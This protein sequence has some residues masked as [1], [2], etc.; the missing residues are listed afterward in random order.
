M[1]DER[2]LLQLHIEPRE[3]IEV[4]EL[5]GALSEVAHQ[6]DVFIREQDYFERAEHGRLLISN[7]S[8][9]SID[10][11]FIPNMVAAVA[12]IVSDLKV[13]SDFGSHLKWLL[14]NFLPEEEKDKSAVTV[15]DCDDVVNIIKPIAEHGGSQAFN[16]YNGT[17]FQTTINVTAPE[18]REIGEEAYRHKATLLYPQAERRQRVS[19]VWTRLDRSPAK[20]EGSS[21]D[22]GVIEEIDPK[23]KLY[24]L[25]TTCLISSGI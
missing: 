6:Y 12:P 4:W 11:N 23:P 14:G 9:G 17:V 15:R 24:Y 3:A 21:P 16:V 13:V 2:S 7:V 25:L 19:M 8:P 22:K 5:T 10:I 20:T 1:A 18:A